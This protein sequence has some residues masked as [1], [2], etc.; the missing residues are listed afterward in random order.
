MNCSDFFKIQGKS[1]LLMGVFNQKSIAFNVGKILKSLGANLVISV[2]ND[3]INKKISK[4]FPEDLIVTCDVLKEH[5]LINL[6]ETMV[7]NKITL[8]GFLHSL[9]FADFSKGMPPFHEVSKEDFFNALEVST[10]SLIKI[11][12]LIKDLFD[13]KASVVTVSISNLLATSY[14]HL[15]PIKA[16][17]QYTIPYLA[18]SFSEFSEVRFNSVGAGPLKTSASAGIPNYLDNYLF[19]EQLTLRKRSLTTAEVSNTIVFLLGQISSGINGQNIIVDA[20]MNLNSFDNKIVKA[21]VKD[22]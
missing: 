10:Y 8:D 15:G 17:L 12:R 3:E 21:V 20:G 7:V 22:L 5:D 6:K 4:H 14:G 19:S 2:Q 11:C 9:A 18:K 16:T 13:H 1:Y